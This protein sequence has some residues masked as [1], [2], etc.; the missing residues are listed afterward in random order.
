LK[1]PFLL[2]IETATEKCSVAISSGVDILAK[3]AAIKV[4]DHSARLTLLI[5]QC[6]QTAGIQID[7]I[8]AIALSE[9]PGSYTGLRVGMA[10]AKGICFGTGLPLILVP[11]LEA[12]SNAARKAG[13]QQDAYYL[14]MLDAR[15]ME[16]YAALYDA[17]LKQLQAPCAIVL[18][19]ETFKEWNPENKRILYFGNG[20][21]KWKTICNSDGFHHIEVNMNAVDMAYSAHVRYEAK[22]FSSIISAVP[23]YLKNPNITTPKP[24]LTH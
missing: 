18:E 13:G 19:A 20:S 10:T 17:N 16:V 9:G 6:L 7:Q 23:L 12:M 15:R 3:A 8:D 14:P 24:R 5:E 4:F 21:D 2:L 1:Q 11:T 22:E